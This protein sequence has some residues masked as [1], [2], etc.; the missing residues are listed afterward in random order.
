M[1]LVA[2]KEYLETI[3]KVR[4]PVDVF[5]YD[6]IDFVED[7]ESRAFAF[8]AKKISPNLLAEQRKVKAAAI[9][10]DNAMMKALVQKHIG[11][12]LLPKYLVEVELIEGSLVQLFPKLAPDFTVAFDMA[13]RKTRSKGLVKEEFIKHIRNEMGR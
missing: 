10:P 8:W 2:S 1:I 4:K 7:V 3:P 9:V 13:V 12:A 5:K 6:I 11:F